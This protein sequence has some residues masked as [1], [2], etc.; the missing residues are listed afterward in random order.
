[1][2]SLRLLF[3][4]VIRNITVFIEPSD[5]GRMSVQCPELDFPISL[6]FMIL[7][8]LNAE[9]FLS[10]IERV[11]QS[12]EQLVLDETLE[13]E[14]INASLPSGGIGK[15]YKYVDLEKTLHEKICFIQIRNKDD[16][17]CARAIVTGY[18]QRSI[19]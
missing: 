18:S 13:V 14:M 19:K 8:Q 6:P 3:Q 15:R 2:Q 17:C 9:R 1:M 7:S 12:Y 5:L 4:S 16:L 10:E 11:L